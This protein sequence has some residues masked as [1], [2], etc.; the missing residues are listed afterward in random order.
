MAMITLLV[1]LIS[2]IGLFNYNYL[3][4]LITTSERLLD[5]SR[6]IF[7]LKG[8]EHMLLEPW[9]NSLLYIDKMPMLNYHNTFL[10]LGN[11]IGFWFFI[12]LILSFILSIIYIRKI[13]IRAIGSGCVCYN[14][15]HGIRNRA[16]FYFINGKRTL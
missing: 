13:K 2:L 9:G 10:A 8:Y 7:F 3:L 1:F 5:I 16:L 11:K 12:F 14:I 6:L 4:N 15:V